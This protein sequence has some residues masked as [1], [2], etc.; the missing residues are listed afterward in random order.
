[1]LSLPI[2]LSSMVLT[3]MF[4]CFCEEI[5]YDNSQVEEARKELSDAWDEYISS[6]D[7]Q[8]LPQ[9][10]KDTDNEKAV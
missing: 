5:P 10:E 7:I 1:M 3:D 2:F 9:N 6:I 4:M 8:Y